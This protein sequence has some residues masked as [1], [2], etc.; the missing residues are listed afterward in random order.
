MTSRP[1]TLR[2]FIE[3]CPR[4]VDL[5]EANAPIDRSIYA[6]GTA[7]HDCL[8]A[9]GDAGLTGEFDESKLLDAVCLKLMSTGRQGVDAEP[10][11][12]PDAVFAGRDLAERYYRE[13][14][15]PTADAWF[16][17]GFGFD[18]GWKNVSYHD[19]TWFRTRLDV[20]EKVTH[21]DEESYGVGLIVRDYKSAW[22]AGE[23]L[24][25]SIQLRSQA[26]AVWKADPA[27]FGMDQP[28]DFIRREIVNLRTLQTFHADVWTSGNDHILEA[29][30]RQIETAIEAEAVKP[31]TASPG[32]RCVGCMYAG[33]CPDAA[34]FFGTMKPSDAATAYAVAVGVAKGL[35]PFARAA[36][37]EAPALVPGGEVGWRVQ[38]KRTAVSDAGARLWERWTQG[39][40]VDPGA[41]GLVRGLLARIG[42]GVSQV[43]SVAKA[44]FPGR[45]EKEDRETFAATLLNQT[46]GRRFG[47]W[48]DEPVS[49]DRDVEEEE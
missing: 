9:L 18:P 23:S 34:G 4:A 16:E 21:E 45:K 36:A 20:V 32:V 28:P 8:H 42:I 30:M 49:D 27:W 40:T 39:Q 5:Y 46:S 29:W 44:L 31:R 15:L 24:L 10:P 33:S 48:R 14:P 37:Q 38:A 12:A 35:E 2:L 6:I 41:D 19:A 17:K 25:E 7:A 22:P 11:I 26:V 1:T 47:I 3:A 13:R 43:E